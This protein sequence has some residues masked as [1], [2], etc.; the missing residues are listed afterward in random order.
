MR[1]NYRMPIIGI[2]IGPFLLHALETP[3]HGLGVI[4]RIRERSEGRLLASPG[5]VYPALHA[6][7]A[8]SLVRSW[9]GSAPA[10]G[11][12]PRRYYELTVEGVRA[13][14]EQRRALSRLVAPNPLEARSGARHAAARRVRRCL[15]LSAFLVSLRAAAARAR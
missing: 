5:S 11:G 12:R 4:R 10:R 14:E 6:L 15:E 3:A 2:P 13:A 8:R 9:K 7:E 1:N